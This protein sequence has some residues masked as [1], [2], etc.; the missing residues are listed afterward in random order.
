MSNKKLTAEDFASF[1]VTPAAGETYR[2]GTVVGS[3]S[4]GRKVIEIEGEETPLT[5]KTTA[6]LNDKVLI[7]SQ[8]HVLAVQSKPVKTSQSK[9]CS[10]PIRF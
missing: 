9:G 6:V 1:G 8:N 10:K 3:M 5:T 4:D 7:D 2:V